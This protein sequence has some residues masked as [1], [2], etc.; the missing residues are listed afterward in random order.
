MKIPKKDL[1]VNV[2]ADIRE[3]LLLVAVQLFSEKGVEA[4]SMRAIN[5]AAG[6]KNKSAVHY[7][8]G[9]K[10]G[11]LKAIFEW[12]GKQVELAVRDLWVQIE[13]REDKNELSVQELMLVL[14]APLILVQKIPQCGND[15]FKLLSKL[16]L[17]S[18]EETKFAND[19]FESHLLAVYE[20]VAQRLPEKNKEHLRFQLIHSVFGF[21]AGTA[22]LDSKILI[23]IKNARIE[24]NQEMLFAFIDFASGGITNTQV[25]QGQ[26]DLR[27]WANYFSKHAVLFG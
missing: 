15:V 11:I 18:N 22:I 1:M 4:V 6:T 17:D 5:T 27:F 2:K 13:Q 12:V 23:D 24:D 16:L 19:L 14:Y 26:I 10:A 3:R 8:F 9:N 25:S 20:R 7:H 21:I